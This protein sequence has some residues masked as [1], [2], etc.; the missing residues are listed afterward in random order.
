MSA[1]D[2]ESTNLGFNIEYE[3]L[4]QSTQDDD[5]LPHNTIEHHYYDDNSDQA[6]FKS[7]DLMQPI[8]IV[9]GVIAFVII[10]VFIVMIIRVFKLK[11]N[12]NSIGGYSHSY[13]KENLRS[14]ATVNSHDT[15]DIII[16]VK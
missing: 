11:R 8:L 16:I 3:Q 15:H 2:F 4:F 12:Q 10:V 14:Y 1:F 6:S 9:A 5:E 7:T 13:P